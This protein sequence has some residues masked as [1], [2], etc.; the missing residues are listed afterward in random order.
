MLVSADQLSNYNIPNDYWFRSRADRNAYFAENVAALVAGIYCAIADSE[1]DYDRGKQDSTAQ[2][3]E[4]EQYNGVNWQVYTVDENYNLVIT[5]AGLEAVPADI[6]ENKKKI[7]FQEI[8]AASLPRV[9][10]DTDAAVI[11]GNYAIDAGLSAKR[12]GLF[13]E[14]SSSP[15][16]NVIAVKAGNENKPAIQALIKAVQSDKVRKYIDEKYPNGDVVVVF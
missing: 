13:I 12:D 11:N 16:V 1:E 10:V 2:V 9:L 14:G 7:K 15:Y 5:T 6:T 8:E 3:W 4:L